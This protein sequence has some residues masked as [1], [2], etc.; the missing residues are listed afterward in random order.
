MTL[1]CNSLCS[2]LL[3]SCVLFTFVGT[4]STTVP[5]PLQTCTQTGPPLQVT[6]ST[7]KPAYK[8][9]ETITLAISVNKASEGTLTIAPPSGAPSTFSYTIPGP[10]F[11]MSKTLIASQAIGKWTVTLQ[12]DDFCAGFSSATAY[13]DVTPDIYDVSISL[14]GIPSQSTVY[15]QVD[16]QTQGAMKGSEIKKLSFKVGTTHKIAVD[17]YVAG[18]PGIRYFEPD[19]SWI[20]GITNAH[21]FA[22]ETQYLFTVATDPGNVT[23]IT[24]SGWFTA[25]STV[26]TNQAPRTVNGPT[27]PEYVFNGWE[28]DGTP[29]AGNPISLT[30]DKPH[31]ATAKYTLS[32]TSTPTSLSPLST[33]SYY[34]LAAAI[35]GTVLSVVAYVSVSRR[36]IAKAQPVTCAQCG[37]R[38]PFEN[39]YCGKCGAA[40]KES[41]RVY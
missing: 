31:T 18:E 9:G 32:Q 16:G 36:K 21:T 41:T 35:F 27:G 3:L 29:Q 19:N 14:S 20:V 28:V 5:H 39:Q 37:W 15:I 6:I 25:G 4:S 13:F 11:T 34:W 22:Y 8:P 7:D 24:G 2:V 26:Q 12:A 38:N 1:Q 30:L 17:E 10:P 33:E 23:Q 40:L